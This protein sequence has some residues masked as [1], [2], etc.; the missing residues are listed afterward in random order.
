MPSRA[1]PVCLLSAG[2]ATGAQF[3]AFDFLEGRSEYRSG[4]FGSI[5]LSS[6]ANTGLCNELLRRISGA[7]SDRRSFTAASLAL[8][9]FR[10]AIAVVGEQAVATVPIPPSSFTRHPMARRR[11]RNQQY[12]E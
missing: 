6:V 8:G 4:T 12:L 10:V 9:F 7:V 1:I 2:E 3:E 5:R 11:G